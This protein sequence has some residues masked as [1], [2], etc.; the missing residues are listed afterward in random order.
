[1]SMILDLLIHVGAEWYTLLKGGGAPPVP[2]LREI[3]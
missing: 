1:M 2:P 3:C